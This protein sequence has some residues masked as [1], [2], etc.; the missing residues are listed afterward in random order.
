M[1]TAGLV[2]K[3]DSG[4]KFDHCQEIYPKV[5]HDSKCGNTLKKD[6]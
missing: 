3:N 4:E 6:K 2:K 5:Q 1:K